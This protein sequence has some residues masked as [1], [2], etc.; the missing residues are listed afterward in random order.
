[1]DWVPGR[2]WGWLGPS[3]SLCNE[4]LIH[5]IH[6]VGRPALKR[7]AV[8]LPLIPLIPIPSILKAWQLI[9]CCVVRFGSLQRKHHCLCYHNLCAHWVSVDAGR[10]GRRAAYLP[11]YSGGTWFWV[12]ESLMG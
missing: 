11:S 3:G 4:L 10:K 9:V 12:P 8:A 5:F 6:S 1:M 2:T 7:R